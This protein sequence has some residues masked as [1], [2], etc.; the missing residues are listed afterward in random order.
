[1]VFRLSLII[2][3]T[4][5]LTACGHLHSRSAKESNEIEQI[6]NL[7]PVSE[8][9]PKSEN[10]PDLDQQ[11]EVVILNNQPTAPVLTN[12]DLIQRIRD[13]FAFPDFNSKHIPQYE[14][15]SARHPT[16]LNNLLARAEPF[17]YYIVE[18]IEKRNLPTELALLPAIESAYKPN[19]MSRSRAVGLWQFIPSTG[20]HFGLRQDWWYD[21]RRDVIAATTAALDYL[22]ELNALF[23]GDWLLTLAA[24]NAGQGTI[25][26]AIKSN[27]RKH[28]GT[29]YQDLRLR[30]ETE[31]YIPK[32]YALKNIISDPEKHRVTLPKIS[33]QPY[34][35][36]IKLPGQ[37][38]L[39]EFTKQADLEFAELKNLNAGFRR[40][41]TP[42]DGPHRLIVPL[43]ALSKIRTAIAQLPV[44][45]KVQYR[46]HVIQQGDTLSGI[47]RKYGVS[48]KTLK[49]TNRLNGT[50]IR[51]GHNLVI[52]SAAYN[53]LNN[54]STAQTNKLIHRVEAGDTLWSIARRYSVQVSQLL[55]WN[56]LRANQILSLNQSLLVFLN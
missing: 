11:P 54:N 51:A 34:F 4:L 5:S 42:A 53:H 16:Y 7:P 13:G 39:H 43:T 3:L 49:S 37:I 46:S 31:R 47:A 45:N 17:L 56:K 38:D 27:K 30:S 41:A 22:E 12:Q 18:E 2:Y 52:P 21:G 26:K 19:A 35:E 25:K 1:M 29:R 48:V 40:W 15:W 55:S 6:P 8:S 9:D 10:I 28:R 24:Y 20:R 32:L 50:T 14:R 44:N 36:V 33:N 23:D